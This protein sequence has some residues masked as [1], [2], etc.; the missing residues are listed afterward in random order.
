MN[1]MTMTESS[2]LVYI[3]M[4]PQVATT[5]HD[6]NEFFTCEEKGLVRLFDLRIK[7]SC[8]CNGCHQ[9]S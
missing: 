9:V 5:P 7:S 2:D 8:H 4:H 3:N 6:P 1:H